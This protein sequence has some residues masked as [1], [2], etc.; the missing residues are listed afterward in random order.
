MVKILWNLARI[1]VHLINM[2]GIGCIM[3]NWLR[4]SGPEN[5]FNALGTF[6]TIVFI[7]LA[8]ASSLFVQYGFDD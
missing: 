1:F 8:V 4:V 3:D 5:M 2:F 7:G 6:A